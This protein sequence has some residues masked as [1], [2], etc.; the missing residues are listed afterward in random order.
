MTDRSAYPLI[1]IRL[2][3]IAFVRCARRLRLQADPSR[4]LRHASADRALHQL[5]RVRQG[6]CRRRQARAQLH[7]ESR[8]GGQRPAIVLD[9]DETSLSNWPAYRVN[10]WARSPPARTISNMGLATSGM[11]GD[12]GVEGAPA[13]ARSGK[14]GRII[15][16]R[17]LLHHGS[18]SRRCARRPSGT[19]A[20]RAI[21]LPR[22]PPASRRNLQERGRLQGAGAA[23]DRRAGL[24]DHL[25]HGRSGQRPGWRI[26]QKTFKLPNPVLP[27]VA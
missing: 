13:D 16:R 19:C 23:E 10:G 5:G 11:A 15:G 4:P 1:S 12:G 14:A 20:A 3:I 26:A 27:A 25:E 21:G 8:T 24:H 9:I 17:R 2:A 6:V 7:G 22:H 18:S